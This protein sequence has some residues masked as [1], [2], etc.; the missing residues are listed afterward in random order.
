MQ[1]PTAPG[2]P[3]AQ[4]P[5][6]RACPSCGAA[7][8][9]LAAFCWQCYR[10]FGAAAEPAGAPR[11]AGYPGAPYPQQGLRGATFAPQPLTAPYARPRGNLGAMAAVV[12]LSLSAVAGVFFF[13][14]RAPGVELPQGFGGLTQVSNA[15][16]DAALEMFRTQADAEGVAA[17]MGIY[18]QAGVPSV[19]LAWV[20][21]GSVPNADAAFDEFAGGF[22]QGLG[23][24]TLDESR[25]TTETI[26]GVSYLCAP[27]TGSPPANICMWEKDDIF[28]ILFD[29]SGATMGATRDLASTANAAVAS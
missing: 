15:Q 4:E 16:V 8:G 11:G 27:V 18:G 20:A 5:D 28:W 9:Q 25:R 17:D 26:D 21:D 23:T 19:A 29:L 2:G 12:L 14:H 1:A 24:G 6:E 7:N 10:P 13:M 3:P 22:N